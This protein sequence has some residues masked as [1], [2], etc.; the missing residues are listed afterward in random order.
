MVAC[1]YR[2]D[3]SDRAKLAQNG[4]VKVTGFPTTHAIKP[5]NLRRVDDTS[6]P[7]VRTIIDIPS[8]PKSMSLLVYETDAGTLD[9]CDK[10]IDKLRKIVG[11]EGQTR[12]LFTKEPFYTAGSH[13][14]LYFCAFDQIGR[15]FECETYQGKWRLFQS[16]EK[17]AEPSWGC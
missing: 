7:M 2:S 10:F 8:P 15:H 9:R 13:H 14:C 17:D 16:F 6:E 4:R 3:D 12:H 11:V 5:T 1:C